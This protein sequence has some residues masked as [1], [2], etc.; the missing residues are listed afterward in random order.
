MAYA[1]VVQGARFATLEVTDS[2][3]ANEV[4]IPN[5]RE[6]G[7]LGGEANLVSVPE[8]GRTRARQIAGQQEPSEFTVS[9]NWVGSEASLLAAYNAG[10]TGTG[11][12]TVDS[13]STN[14]ADASTH[15]KLTLKDSSA[16][17]A[18]NTT[19]RWQG[20]LAAANMSTDL[21][22]SPILNCTISVSG[23][24]TIGTDA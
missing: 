23:D 17:N 7:D 21:N 5:V 20:A 2:S 19:F 1:T 4:A 6:I 10:N 12:V 8:F 3:G 9:F 16:T 22:D 24:I 11:A 15:W 14:L 13:T 18:A